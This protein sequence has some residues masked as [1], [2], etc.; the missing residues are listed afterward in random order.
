MITR[1]NQAEVVSLRS[2]ANRDNSSINSSVMLQP[3]N[4]SPSNE[5]EDAGFENNGE[6]RWDKSV[7][8]AMVS[9]SRAGKND[10]WVNTAGPG[11]G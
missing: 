10:R 4:T 5:G 3:K 9:V 7:L 6:R 11:G 8:C 1:R 2:E